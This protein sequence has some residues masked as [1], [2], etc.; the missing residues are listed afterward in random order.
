MYLKTEYRQIFLLIL[1]L[2]SCNLSF[3][4]HATAGAFEQ[5]SKQDSLR[6]LLKQWTQK[7]SEDKKNPAIM[8]TIAGLYFQIGKND[9]AD[10]WLDLSQKMDR[11]RAE[12]Y[13]WRGRVFLRRGKI[14]IIPLE[15]L[16]AIIKQD[17]YS[18]AIKNFK[19]AIEI[20]P[21]YLEAY[22]YLGVTHVKKGGNKH[23]TG[24]VQAYQ[25]ILNRN[26]DF[27]DTSFQLG[28][29]YHK[30]KQ[31][32]KAVKFMNGY[33]LKHPKDSRPFIEMSRIFMDKGDTKKASFYF[34]KGVENLRDSN[35]LQ[36]LFLEIKD[37]ATAEEK[38]EFETSPIEKKGA[39]FKKFWKSRDPTPFTTENE[40]FTEHYRRVQFARTTYPSVIPPYYDDRGRVYVKYGKPDDRYTSSMD[41]SGT[42]DNESWSYQKSIRR[43]LVFDFVQRGNMYQLVH[44]LT[45]AAP[46][47]ADYGTRLSIAGQLYS[48]RAGDLGGIY[49]QFSINFR[50]SDLSDFVNQ[51]DAAVR[52]APV[53]VYFHDYKMKP[54]PFRVKFAQFRS[55]HNLTW[56]DIYRSLATRNLQFT[57]TDDGHFYS[58][59]KTKIVI[60]D[61]LYNQVF[62]RSLPL[63]LSFSSEQQVQTAISIDQTYAVLNPKNK[64]HIA[65][66][67]E[68]PQGKKLGIK[69]FNLNIRQYDPDSLQISDIE[70]ASKIEPA[71]KVDQFYKDGLKVVPYMFNS[72]DIK[73]PLKLYYEIYNLTLD[74]EKKSKYQIDYKITVI[75]RDENSM[76]K[77]FRA[78]GSVLGKRGK[79]SIASSYIREGKSRNEKEYI[80]LDVSKMPTGINQ[81]SVIVKD[82][83]TNQ[84]QTSKLQLAFVKH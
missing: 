48:E 11:N 23:F 54:L 59:I 12:T 71:S 5:D 16:L 4:S 46:T 61:S 72:H 9:S 37:I 82:L 60:F 28:I 52:S 33:F 39:F 35:M 7:L 84:I 32:E 50:Q 43:G 77:I 69:K 68:N 1:F 26:N 55:Q 42:K 70:L 40:R 18:K 51:K 29:A 56:L 83:F 21:D 25:T 27:K 47:G 41:I 76:K 58:Q 75:K 79:Q 62:R 22:Y 64:Y 31:Y 63:D 81:V 78:I 44:D 80:S 67:V 36:E 38:K 10:F 24:A 17:N 6:Q 34:M 15:K 74:K 2:F 45:A 49:N 14:G 30:L 8:N 53:E 65:I 13:Y 20:N 19:K 66:Q 3:Y 57:T 73:K